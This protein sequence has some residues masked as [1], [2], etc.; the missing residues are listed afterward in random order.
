[1]FDL[2]NF[3]KSQFTEIVDTNSPEFGDLP[4]EADSFELRK[5]PNTNR[6]CFI[7]STLSVGGISD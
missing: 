5:I 4:K 7:E 1:M 2:L 3:L 6:Y